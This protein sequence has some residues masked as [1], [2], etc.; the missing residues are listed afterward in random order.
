M[1]ESSRPSRRTFLAS[2]AA[3][4]AGVWALPGSTAR[5]A[6]KPRYPI[7][8]FSK[9]FQNLSFDQTADT[10]AQIGW[11]G[12]ECPVRPGGQ[13]EPERAAEE[14]P[15]LIE[16]LAKRGKTL[17]LLTTSITSP[18]QPHA[19]SLLRLAAKLGIKRYRLGFVHYE[20]DRPIPAQLAKLQAQL[21]DLAKLN[22]ELGLQ[23]GFQNHSG[24]TNVGAP[25]WDIWTVIKDLDPRAIGVCFDIGH[26]T[27]EGGLSWPIDARLLAPRFSAVFVKDFHWQKRDGRWQA[28]WT[29]LGQGMVDRQFFT[30]LKTT[31][32]AGPIVQHHEYD[33]GQGA[34]MIA[35]M[36]QDLAVLRE[37]L[38]AG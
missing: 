33:H 13:I 8:G 26:A 14:L 9:P 19:E 15:K 16:E 10:V 12:I 7:L 32:F 5:A 24:A 23:A 27:L 6:E 2:T 29:P 17:G 28:E 34:P 18:S 37:W 30:W 25:A 36:R 1:T 11:D 35:K 4:A 22:L 38:Q 31:D 3:A 20:P 21:A